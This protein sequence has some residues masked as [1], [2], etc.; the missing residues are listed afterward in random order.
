MALRTRTKDGKVPVSVRL[1]EE[2]YEQ[3]RKLAFEAGTTEGKYS[4]ALLLEDF[5]KRKMN[6]VS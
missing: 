2:E 5:K 1:K 6:V 3:L 4:R